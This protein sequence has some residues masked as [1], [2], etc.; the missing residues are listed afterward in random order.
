MFS[1]DIEMD[2]NLDKFAKLSLKQRAKVPV[3]GTEVH[4]G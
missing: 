2:F 1:R 3:E 4:D